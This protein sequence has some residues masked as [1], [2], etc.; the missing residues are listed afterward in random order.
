VWNA[1]VA[2]RPLP[3]GEIL[4]EADRLL[5]GC[6]TVSALAP[7]EVQLEGKKRMPARDFIH[8]YHLKS[9]EKFG[10]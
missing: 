9:G 5:V 10:T 8:G 2:Q 4:V 7:L 6:E 3:P 1:A